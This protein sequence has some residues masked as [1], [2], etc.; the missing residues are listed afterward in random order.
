MTSLSDCARELVAWLATTTSTCPNSWTA[1]FTASAGA[2]GREK[3]L[4]HARG[5]LRIASVLR[6]RRP[7]LQHRYPRADRHRE[8]SRT[9]LRRSFQA[10]AAS[11]NG[12]PNSNAPT[13]PCDN[14]DPASHRVAHDPL[15]RIWITSVRSAPGRPVR[16]R[17]AADHRF[18]SVPSAIHLVWNTC[19]PTRSDE[20]TTWLPVDFVAPQRI[21]V[22]PDH[23]LRPIKESDADVD[24]PAVMG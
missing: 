16:I 12:E 21:L 13:D 11:C 5:D 15:S 20:V 2:P 18:V 1:R 7:S 14:G 3:W 24:Y 23:H 6:E 10:R 9:G 19:E 17:T 8:R 4:R 22:P